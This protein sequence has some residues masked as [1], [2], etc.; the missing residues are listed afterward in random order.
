KATSSASSGRTRPRAARRSTIDS[1]RIL[2]TGAAYLA[3]GADTMRPDRLTTKSQEAVRDALDRAGRLGNPELLPE[4][5]LVA[6]LEQEGGVAAPLIQK[7]GGDAQALERELTTKL[8]G[9]P[10]VTGGAQ[11][12]MGRRTLEAFRKAEDEAKQ[13][14]DDFVS[15]EHFVLGIVKADRDLQSMFER[16]GGVTYDKLLKALASVR[17]NQRVTDRDP[18]GKFQALEK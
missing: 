3:C 9:M 13:L 12:S 4:H 10:R 2:R 5:L 16:A 7:A 17:G 14:K 6:M 8:E 1:A 18:E 15:V 11:P